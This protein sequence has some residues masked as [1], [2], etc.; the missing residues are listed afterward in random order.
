MLLLE[1]CNA[2]SLQTAGR[3]ARVQ[4]IALHH[5]LVEVQRRHFPLRLSMQGHSTA[6]SLVFVVDADPYSYSSYIAH[7]RP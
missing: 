5:R 6:L 4:I 3:D 2:T 1:T 7:V